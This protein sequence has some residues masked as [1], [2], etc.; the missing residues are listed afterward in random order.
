MANVSVAPISLVKSPPL[1]RAQ[2]GGSG[3]GLAIVRSAVESFGGSVVAGS[4]APRGLRLV[5]L[6]P[7]ADLLGK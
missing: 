2:A 7:A 3:L 5:F 6:L 4:N 1:E